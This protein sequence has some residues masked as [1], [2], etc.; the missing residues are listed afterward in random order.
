MALHMGLNGRWIL[1][2]DVVQHIARTIAIHNNQPG[3]FGW[4]NYRPIGELRLFHFAPLTH[5]Q[6]VGTMPTCCRLKEG[7]SMAPTDQSPLSDAQREI[8]EIIWDRGEAT[9][10]DV[11]EV[12]L[13]KREVARNTVQTM[14][15]RL[16]EKGWLKHRTSGRTFVYAANIPRRTSLGAK[17]SQMV[18]RMF[19]GSP[20][21]LMTALLEY[22]G[23]SSD[24]AE[25]I[26]A[27]ID[28]AEGK[29]D[30]QPQRRRKS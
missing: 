2:A 19:A 3:S 4:Q 22:R 29:S 12:L 21:E 11:R 16:E 26:R 8:M 23:L 6:H 24:E 5:L 30:S 25:R 9:V 17:V 28:E 20:E 7:D 10:S 13:R 14:M 15:V 27:M 18:D 1:L